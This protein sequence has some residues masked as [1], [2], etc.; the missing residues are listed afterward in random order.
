MTLGNLSLQTGELKLNYGSDI[1]TEIERLLPL[2]S[3]ESGLTDHFRPRWLAVKL[4][5]GEADILRQIE[6]LSEGKVLLEQARLS[7]DRIEA[8]Y[9]DSADIAIADARY[10]F[11]HGLTRQIMDTSQVNRYTL[12]DRID[13]F[14]TN[15]IL[16]LP[17]FLA[18]VYV[19]FKLVVDV[20]AP[21]LD[22]V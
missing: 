2:I 14:V 1:E 10:G 13:R 15:R 8:I 18:V 3:R 9:G 21:Y 16:G 20:S 17:I 12:T 4:L 11:I 5:E 19:M 6:Q 7:R 22:W